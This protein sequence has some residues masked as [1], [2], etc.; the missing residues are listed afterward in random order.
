MREKKCCVCGD[1][2]EVNDENFYSRPGRTPES[3]RYPYGPCKPCHKAQSAKWKRDN[4]EQYRAWG[5]Q[6]KRKLRAEVIAAY[7][8]VCVCCGEAHPEFLDMDHIHGGGRAHIKLLQS[9]GQFYVWIKRQGF[10]KDLLRLLCANCNQ[11]RGRYGYCP[12]ERERSA[13]LQI[14]PDGPVH[15][16]AP[17]LPA[18]PPTAD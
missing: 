16:L 7:G 13:A 1:T 12:H 15:D 11:S 18:L 10:P 3:P 14:V 2:K 5:R 4:R 8:G 6:D 9:Q 17:E